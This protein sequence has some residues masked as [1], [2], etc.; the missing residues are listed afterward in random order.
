MIFEQISPNFR[1]DRL[2]TNDLAQKSNEFNKV[3]LKQNKNQLQMLSKVIFTAAI[4]TNVSAFRF[5]DLGN[6]GS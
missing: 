4:A 6:L 1:F 3:K 2:Q 5:G